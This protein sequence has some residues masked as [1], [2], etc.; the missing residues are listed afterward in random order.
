MSDTLL[1]PHEPKW[2]N[3]I[4]NTCKTYL[5]SELDYFTYPGGNERGS[6]RLF[7]KDKSTVIFSWRGSSQRTALE[8]VALDSI[9]RH[10]ECVPRLF[11]FDGSFLWQED[12]KGDTLAYHMHK[13]S[14]SEVFN[15]LD[16]ALQNLLEIHEAGKKAKLDYNKDIPSLGVTYEWYLSVIS[17]AAIIGEKLGHMPPIIDIQSII[18]IISNI[19]PCFIKWDARPGNAMITPD[20]NV[21]WFDWEH[22]GIR[23]QL[24]DL[25][26]FLGD[27]SIPDNS[28]IENALLDKYLPKFRGKKKF[29]AAKEYFY[30]YG[31]LHL[32]VRLEKLLANYEYNNSQ[33]ISTEEC[34]KEDLGSCSVEMAERICQR[35]MRWS[36]QTTLL[37]PFEQWFSDIL[38]I[39]YKG[40]L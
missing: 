11:L 36:G 20:Q 29:G 31:T 6:I 10:S 35:G 25:V 15:A 27:E 14:Q 7:L 13:K 4:S 16:L 18:D 19:E 12:L 32:C 30:I 2:H 3:R 8:S 1:N 21:K 26:W 34:V 24:D 38:R 17:R 22:A 28:H 39:I 5:G 37:Q 33:W 23:N 40:M 9:R